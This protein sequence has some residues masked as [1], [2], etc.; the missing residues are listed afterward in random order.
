[1]TGLIRAYALRLARK[2]RQ[3]RAWRKRGELRPLALRTDRIRPGDILLFSCLRNEAPRLPFFLD[4]YRRLGV[5]HFLVAD[6]GSTDGGTALLAA[7]ADVSLWSATGSYRR[8]RFGMDWL[9]LLLAR[10]GAGHWCLTVDP[11]EFLVYAHSDTRP[12]RALTDWLDA[13]AIRSFG[14]LL[15]D[16]YGEG[17]VAETVC[18]A[19]ADPIAAAPFFDSGNYQ[20]RRD[21]RLGN[22]WI[23]GGPRQRAFFA[24]APERA[25]ALNKIPLVKWRRG[26]VYASSTHSLLPRGLNLVYEEWGGEK[27]SG[28]LL[29]TKFLSTIAA[30]TAE[31]LARRQHYAGSREYRAYDRALRRGLTLHTPRSAR[32]EGWGQLERLG[33]LSA[34]GWL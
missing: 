24:E 13:S 20:I 31:E 6:N 32:Y 34:G 11:D 27:P 30:K 21:P 22:L 17:P 26:Y 3:F 5:D 9:N 2:R 15:V 16:L 23:Q 25:P 28:V 29:H 4:Y 33:L 7:Q 12:L 19:G 14:C 1:M 8:A 10:H 18:P